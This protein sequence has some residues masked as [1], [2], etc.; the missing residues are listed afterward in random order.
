MT[1]RQLDIEALTALARARE[2]LTVIDNTW[3]TPLYQKP[4]TL[5]VDLVVASLSKYIGGHSDVMGG[6][7]IGPA[8]LLQRIFYNAFMLNGATPAP[9]DAYLLIRGLR[10]LPARMRQH[11]MDGLAVA[12]FLAG[13]RTV[14]EVY[15]PALMEVDAGL[16][17]RQLRGCAGL[18]SFVLSDDRF[19]TVERVINSLERFRIGVS[20]GG[21]ESLVIAPNHGHNRAKLVEAGIAPGLIRLSIGLE[22]AEA[23]IADLS[24]ALASVEQSA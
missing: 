13:H 19:S 9:M 8:D 12:R 15:H 4:L 18:F 7:I 6:A 24:L 11:H 14:A 3:A 5:G 20:W 21:V 22:G 23:L 2:I 17:R 1:F 16:T 10:T